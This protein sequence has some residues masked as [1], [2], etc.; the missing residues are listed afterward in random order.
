[1]HTPYES[2]CS[3]IP[4][5]KIFMTR[6]TCKLVHFKLISLFKCHIFKY[7]GSSTS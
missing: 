2:V 5:L 1:M 6:R 4:V 3:H 7:G